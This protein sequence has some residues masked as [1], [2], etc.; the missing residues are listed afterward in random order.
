MQVEK[1]T[2]VK[3]LLM[4]AESLTSRLGRLLD[5]LNAIME[6][7]FTFGDWDAHER[8]TFEERY[9]ALGF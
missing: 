3:P 2:E 5:R 1:T 8:T 7:G 4:S 9:S 6:K